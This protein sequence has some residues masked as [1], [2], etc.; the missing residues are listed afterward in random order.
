MED[1]KVMLVEEEHF[2][3]DLTPQRKYYLMNNLAL[4]VTVQNIRYDTIHDFFYIG[5]AVI[6]NCV[7][8]YYKNSLCTLYMNKI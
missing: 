4:T 5:N 8:F 7:R 6:S 1:L 3:E 2:S